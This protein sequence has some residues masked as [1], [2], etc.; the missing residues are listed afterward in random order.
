[1]LFVSLIA[2]IFLLLFLTCTIATSA[3]AA[4]RFDFENITHN[5]DTN[6]ATGEAQLHFDVTEDNGKI[7]FLF[8]N[9]GP[10]ASSITDIYFDDDAFLLDFSEFRYDTAGGVKFSQWATPADLPGGN[11]VSFTANYSF[12]SDSPVQPNG[13]NPGESLGI[14]F[15][16]ANG[17][18]Y[19]SIIAA[20][21]R[22]DG[23]RVGIHVQGFS[24]GGS[25]SFIN[26]PNGSD[27]VPEPAAMVLF[28]FG[29]IGLAGTVRRT[30]KN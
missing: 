12:D 10:Y 29:L 15:K 18:D 14:L 26:T 17:S 11:D 1:M 19:N 21:N 27:T 3:Y 5:N 20:L 4:P 13:I 28:G 22:T 23:M 16:T 8:I 6:A 9:D 25:E 2:I 30:K 7:L 24:N